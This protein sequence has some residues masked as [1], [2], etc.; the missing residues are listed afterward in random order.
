MST[1]ADL[2]ARVRNETGADV[3]VLPTATLEEF[4]NTARRRIRRR[5]PF[6]QF[7]TSLDIPYGS[8][9]DGT[10][11]PTDFD[12]EAAVW[13][14]DSSQ[15]DPS[16][17]LTPVVKTQRR[18]WIEAI[19]P[20]NLTD[21][22]YPQT[23]RPGAPTF[24]ERFYYLWAET[25][26]IVPQPTAGITLRLDYVRR[27]PELT[28][29]LEDA[30]TNEFGDLVRAAALARAYRYLHELD[31][32]TAADEEFNG[33]LRDAILDDDTIALSGPPPQRG[34]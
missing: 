34:K 18:Q 24:A 12:Y 4:L 30:T 15:A 29:T 13:T 2:V 27:F 10:P 33:L 8:T 31:L 1:L 23:A 17:A 9:Q 6:R 28:G 11:L 32:A 7:Q 20:Q 16:T 26:W 3:T 22:V 25:L 21:Q 19:D 5:H 14:F